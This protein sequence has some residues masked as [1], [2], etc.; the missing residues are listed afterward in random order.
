MRNAQL[1]LA[2]ARQG[3]VPSTWKI[4]RAARWEGLLGS[5]FS[6]TRRDPDPLIIFIPEGVIQYLDENKPLRVIEFSSLSRIV[7]RV[8]A[9]PVA[10]MASP[11]WLELFDLNGKKERWPS[12]GWL[13]ATQFGSRLTEE[14]VQYFIEAYTRYQVLP[15]SETTEMD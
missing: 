15:G 9:T 11:V 5:L 4:F 8:D 3:E 2:Q 6:R 12:A 13:R 10:W 7:L 1:I 14:I